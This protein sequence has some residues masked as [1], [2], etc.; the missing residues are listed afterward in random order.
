MTAVKPLFPSPAPL[1]SAR[2]DALEAAR[3]L[4][5]KGVKL[6]SDLV[7]RIQQGIVNTQD[8]SVARDF[9]DGHNG[10]AIVLGLLAVGPLAAVVNAAVDAASKI[11]T[12][13]TLIDLMIVVALGAVVAAVA[14]PAL[15]DLRQRM[16]QQKDPAV[17]ELMGTLLAAL[18]AS[19]A[20]T[21]V[22]RYALQRDAGAST[23][24]A[25]AA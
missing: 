11:N 2:A 4:H 7:H 22:A 24:H 23:A 6:P 5:S 9:L 25:L 17:R 18:E 20:E 8:V 12:N 13:T 14:L 3:Q 19:Q 16:T 10:R 1:T 15:K 21:T